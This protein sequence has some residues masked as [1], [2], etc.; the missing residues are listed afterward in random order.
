MNQDLSIVTLLLNASFVVQLVVFILFTVSIT[1][2]TVIFRKLFSL[3]KIR[4]LNENFEKD[5]WSGKSLNELFSAATQNA[6]SAGPMEQGVGYS[7]I[8]IHIL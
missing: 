7:H 4:A 8:H 5:F 3:R 6:R 1:S 2:W